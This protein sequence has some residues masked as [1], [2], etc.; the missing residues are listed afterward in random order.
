MVSFCRTF[1]SKAWAS[2]HTIH[3]PSQINIISFQ[4]WL[5][6]LVTSCCEQGPGFGDPSIC[7]HNVNTSLSSVNGFQRLCLILPRSYVTEMKTESDIRK[8][9]LQQL[10][11]LI[12]YHWI[13]VQNGNMRNLLVA[14]LRQILHDSKSNTSRSAF[15]GRSSKVSYMLWNLLEVQL[16]TYQ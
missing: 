3:C 8:F 12:S 15:Q 16:N 11:G 5:D 9:V 2:I 14:R 6:R 13:D 4:V 1:Q 7:T 10:H